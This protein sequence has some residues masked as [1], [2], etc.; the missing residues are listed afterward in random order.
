MPIAFRRGSFRTEAAPCDVL[1]RFACENRFVRRIS[2]LDWPLEAHRGRDTNELSDPEFLL[3]AG[4]GENVLVFRR[5]GNAGSVDAW[6]ALL[7]S[8]AQPYAA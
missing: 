7:V 5:F 4:A 2:G 3:P 6:N 1:E 8:A